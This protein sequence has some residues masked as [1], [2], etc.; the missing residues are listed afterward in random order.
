VPG[1]LLNEGRYSLTLGVDI[2][3]QKVL[4]LEEA[5]L[6]FIV[7]QTGGASARFREKWPGVV[8]PQLEWNTTNGQKCDDSLS[9]NS[10]RNLQAILQT[11][12]IDQ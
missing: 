3:H 5:A 12:S 10:S 11:K 2:P 4:A 1:N 9:L 6:G 8:C 7:E